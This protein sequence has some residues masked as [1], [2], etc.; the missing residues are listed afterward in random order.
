MSPVDPGKSLSLSLTGLLAL[1]GGADSALSGP[2]AAV[3][4]KGTWPC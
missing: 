4:T 3:L 1:F 2:R